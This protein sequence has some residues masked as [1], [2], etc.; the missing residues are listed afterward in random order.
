MEEFKEFRQMFLDKCKEDEDQGEKKQRKS[1]IRLMENDN[2][3]LYQQQLDLLP[4]MT[5]S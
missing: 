5:D 1:L 4:N 3:E 2:I